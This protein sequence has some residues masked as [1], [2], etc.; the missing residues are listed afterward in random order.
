MLLGEH[1]ALH[2]VRLNSRFLSRSSS[3]CRRSR[4]VYFCR[5]ALVN[6]HQHLSIMADLPPPPA[7]VEVLDGPADAVPAGVEA[8]G[9]AV[10]PPVADAEVIFPFILFSIFLEFIFF[11]TCFGSFGAAGSI[12]LPSGCHLRICSC[13]CLGL[14][15]QFS[16]FVS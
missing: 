11:A 9:G 4:G 16:F 2:S 6:R 7:P 13:R 14:Y 15:V 8:V 5:S 12:L 3:F 1:D 10:P